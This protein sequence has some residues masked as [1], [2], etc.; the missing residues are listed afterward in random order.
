MFEIGN[1][2]RRFKSQTIVRTEITAD[3]LEDERVGLEALG[4]EIQ[5]QVR[6][7]VEKSIE[8]DAPRLDNGV[9]LRVAGFHREL[10]AVLIV[11]SRVPPYSNDNVHR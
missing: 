9:R 6:A 2:T 8:V 4:R 11:V 3:H 5:G 1:P 10:M 7:N